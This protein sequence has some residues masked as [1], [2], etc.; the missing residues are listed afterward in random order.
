MRFGPYGQSSGAIVAAFEEI[1][2]A[3]TGELSG[4]AASLAGLSQPCQQTLG[5]ASDNYV[6][7]RL[8]HAAISALESSSAVC[9]GLSRTR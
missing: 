1:A 2:P 5:G 8:H 4:V 7:A 6:S 9:S 3:L